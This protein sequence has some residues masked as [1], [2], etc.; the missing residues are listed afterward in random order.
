MLGSVTLSDGTDTLGL[1]NTSIG[2]L[3]DQPATG[4]ATYA[5]Q[6]TEGNSTG[7]TTFNGPD[8]LT[9]SASNLVVLADRGLN[10][11]AYPSGVP[12]SVAVP[13]IIS[14]TINEAPVSLSTSQTA[15]AT[16][17]TTSITLQQP[18]ELSTLV[19]TATLSGGSP[20]TLTAGSDFALGADPATGHTTINFIITAG[21]FA[22]AGNPIAGTTINATYAL[23]ITLQHPVNLSTLV[24]TATPSGGSPVVLTAGSDYT[25][26]TDPATGNTTIAF[27]DGRHRGHFA[28][29]N[30]IVIASHSGTTI[31]S[32]YTYVVQPAAT[33]TLAFRRS[34][35]PA[36]VV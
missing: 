5:L 2:V 8:G 18:V 35:V 28:A 33:I 31:G 26:G 21:N 29:H 14:S 10:L 13:A 9:L 22:A 12:P 19:V 24:V 23:A 4:Q 11:S 17:S 15:Q 34:T 25:L 16:S 7:N 3:V 1:A 27:A 20:V 30:A 32:S 36:R 6:A